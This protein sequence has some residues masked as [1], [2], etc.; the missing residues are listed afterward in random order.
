MP[1]VPASEADLRERERLLWAETTRSQLLAGVM[2]DVSSSIDA[3]GILPGALTVWGHRATAVIVGG[4]PSERRP[5][6]G[7]AERTDGVRVVAF[8]HEALLDGKTA[9]D[10]AALRFVVSAARWAGAKR[11]CGVHASE[12]TGI[13][14][15]ATAVDDPS[16]TARPLRVAVVGRSA[17]WLRALLDRAPDAGW[18]TAG[19]WT[20]ETECDVVVWHG[21]TGSADKLATA[22]DGTSSPI[23]YTA[24]V[25]MCPRLFSLPL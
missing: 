10:S 19:E 15:D 4:P 17:D 6:V 22:V 25:V 5:V 21:E 18:L 14:S 16:T 23:H 12:N 2:S 8:A 20:P 9:T 11:C 1:P 7:A 24:C 3:R 13:G